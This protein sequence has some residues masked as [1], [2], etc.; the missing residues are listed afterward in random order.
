MLQQIT[1]E[2]WTKH[3][4]LGTKTP[5]NK[6][7]HHLNTLHL[8]PAQIR[9][10]TKKELPNSHFKLVDQSTSYCSIF[11]QNE[12]LVQI[13]VI[14][15]SHDFGPDYT[16][17]GSPPS[18]YTLNTL[19]KY[20]SPYRISEQLALTLKNRICPE[21]FHCI[22]YTFHIQDFW[23]TLRL[24]WNFSSWWGGSLPPPRTPISEL[25]C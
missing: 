15:T 18:E 13:K 20:F 22:G 3:E 14:I 2:F 9:K 17:H 5:V 6:K 4:K 7:I 12:G 19:L 25:S 8:Y 16:L 21:I 10:R 1:E 24:P 11:P 23:A